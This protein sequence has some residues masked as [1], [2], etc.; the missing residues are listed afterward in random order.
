MKYDLLI[1]II[2]YNTKRYLEIC[3][4][5]L[6]NDLIDSDINY[7]IIVLDNNS[8]DNLSDIKQMCPD[9]NISFEYSKENLGFG[10]GHNYIST[11]TNSKYILILNSDIKFIE[12]NSVKRL[13]D[14]I[15]N[16]RYKVTGPKLVEE[17][18]AQQKF[19]HGELYGINSII[20]N[21]YGSSYWRPRQKPVE[22]AWVS[23]A[24]FMIETKLFRDVKGFDQKFFLYKEEEDLCKRIRNEG[25]KILYN[26]T[27]S[28]MHFGHVVAKRSEHF[29]DSMNYYLD[30]HFR[31]NLSYKLLHSLK[32][33]KDLTLHGKVKDRK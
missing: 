21:N 7:K 31:K 19:D 2:N 33:I 17:D 25:E 9:K 4:K 24:V 13:F 12:R 22:A 27:I 3:L 11:L 29:S 26:P 5:S 23:G 14:G 8:N 20:K 18:L 28:V 15:I 30:K 10:G 16:T 1:Q 6:F 32:V